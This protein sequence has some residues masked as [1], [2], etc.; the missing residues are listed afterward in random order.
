MQEYK[1]PQDLT[2]N[3]KLIGTIY[4]DISTYITR[5]SAKNH[6][7]KKFYGYPFSTYIL[8]LLRAKEIKKIRIV[9]YE[10][11]DKM[12]NIYEARVADFDNLKIFQEK[13]FDEQK[14]LQLRLY[15][16]IN[17]IPE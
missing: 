1:E 6:W 10:R 16:L 14:C 3:G 12:L 7:M 17:S 9:E 15:R 2:L 8:K 11:D 13:G 4:Y 5:R